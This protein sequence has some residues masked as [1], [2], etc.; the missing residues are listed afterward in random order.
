MQHPLLIDCYWVYCREQMLLRRPTILFDMHS[1]G[2]IMHLLQ[3]WSWSLYSIMWELLASWINSI[4][5]WRNWIGNGTLLRKRSLFL[6]W[7]SLMPIMHSSSSDFSGIGI[8][9]FTCLWTTISSNICC[10]FSHCVY[11]EHEALL[12]RSLLLDTHSENKCCSPIC[13]GDS[14]V[15]NVLECRRLLQLWPLHTCNHNKPVEMDGAQPFQWDKNC[16]LDRR[17]WP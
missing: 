8:L 5:T 6:E 15:S 17:P 16:L 13:F 12:V 1:Q 9:S 2:F 4:K 11:A 7:N 10:H 3:T 14:L